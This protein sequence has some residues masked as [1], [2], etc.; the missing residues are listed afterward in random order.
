MLTQ[1]NQEFRRFSWYTSH[2]TKFSWYI[3]WYTSLCTRCTGDCTF[4][5][6]CT[7]VRARADRRHGHSPGYRAKF[8]SSTSTAGS[9][10]LSVRGSRHRSPL[11][12]I[13]SAIGASSSQTITQ[14]VLQL[15]QHSHKCQVYM[16]LKLV[17]SRVYLVQRLVCH[18][19]LVQ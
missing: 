5:F 13:L 3:Y 17:Q 16:K 7:L 6:S 8:C 12:C 10:C 14:T 4:L 2:C 1:H 19:N 18:E 11:G 15:G 9:C